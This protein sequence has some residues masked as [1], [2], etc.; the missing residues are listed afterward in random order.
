MSERSQMPIDR[1]EVSILSKRVFEHLRVRTIGELVEVD[2]FTF[3]HAAYAVA[4]DDGRVA[5][6]LLEVSAILAGMGLGLADDRE[7]AFEKTIPAD[8]AARAGYLYRGSFECSGS[9]VL[10]ESRFIGRSWDIARQHAGT[11][12]L[13]ETPPKRELGSLELACLDVRPGLWDVYASDSQ[14]FLRPLELLVRHRDAGEQTRMQH[15]GALHMPDGMAAVVD[16]TQASSVTHL[17]RS[18]ARQVF[19]WGATERLWHTVD[20]WGKPMGSPHYVWD[21]FIG[22]NDTTIRCVSIHAWS[23]EPPG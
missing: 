22:P 13:L 11:I 6:A 14:R 1:L 15:I 23:G 12:D 7:P 17:V 19:D 16:A 10:G 18:Y 5:P 20:D 8:G 9:L 4:P 21:T 3:M 2:Q